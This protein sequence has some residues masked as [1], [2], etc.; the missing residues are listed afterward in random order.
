M[1]SVPVLMISFTSRVLSFSS[2]FGKVVSSLM[3]YAFVFPIG[4]E[5]YSAGYLFLVRGLFK[6]YFLL[7]G[8][9]QTGV[10]IS[11][12][13]FNQSYLCDSI[14]IFAGTPNLPTRLVTRT[15]ESNICASLWVASPWAQ[16]KWNR[17]SFITTTGPGRWIYPCSEFAIERTCWD[18]KDGELCL[19][20]ARPEE[21][22]VEARSGF[23]VQ[24]NRRIWV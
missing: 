11:L 16:W 4:L 23:D 17:F 20:R 1:I 22:L 24:I 9:G 5:L 3:L 21:T 18:P 14:C 19:N 12:H 15:K 8:F 6:F 7:A 13:S 2:H 10:Y